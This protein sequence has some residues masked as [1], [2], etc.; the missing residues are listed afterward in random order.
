MTDVRIELQR[1]TE[2]LL[3]EYPP[4]AVSGR[5]IAAAA[6]VNYGRVHR[7]F[8]SKDQL[9]QTTVDEMVQRYLSDARPTGALTPTPGVLLRHE[10][11]AR[12]VANLLLDDPLPRPNPVERLA[13]AH[14]DGIAAL[15]EDL[16]DDALDVVACLAVAIEFAGVIHWRQLERIRVLS[17]L[18]A[19]VHREV[20]HALTRLIA[21]RGPFVGQPRPVRVAPRSLDPARPEGNETVEERLIVAASE[22]LAEK[23]PS[24]ITGRELAARAGVNYGRIHSTFGSASDVCSAAIDLESARLLDGYGS[25]DLP[26][27]FSMNAHPGFVRF[28]TRLS[29]AP[30]SGDERRFFPFLERLYARHEDRHGAIAPV[31]RFR[32]S[33]SVMTQITWA[34]LG[35]S[36]AAALQRPIDELEPTAAGYLGALIRYES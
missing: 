24:A 21:G 23:A 28:L 13:T 8:G 7:H 34:L 1:A 12:S 10:S 18:E 11:F 6:D 31:T 20:V 19:S 35:P 25:A 29:L 36:L 4:S 26:G 32:Y 3:A 22:L 5:Q 30:D 16:P 15:R 2:R 14:R 9:I 27:F 33:L 17:G